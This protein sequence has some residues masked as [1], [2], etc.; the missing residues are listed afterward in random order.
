MTDVKSNRDTWAIP[1][2]DFILTFRFSTNGCPSLH[3]SQLQT[4]CCN[5]TSKYN[6]KYY[7]AGKYARS[8]WLNS[9]F[10][11]LFHLWLLPSIFQ[12]LNLLLLDLFLGCQSFRIFTPTAHY[13]Q[14]FKIRKCTSMVDTGS[15]PGLSGS[16]HAN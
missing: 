16:Y 11:I 4:L 3:T 7:I 2:N 9:H 14:R 5:F 10:K 6:S 12:W 8:C 15:I 1:L 13:L